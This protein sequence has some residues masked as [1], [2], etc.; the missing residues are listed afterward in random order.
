M[1]EV[2]TFRDLATWEGSGNPVR[3][4][5]FGDPVARSL[6]PPMQNAALAAAGETAQYARFEITAPELAPALRKLAALNF[7]GVNLTVPHKIAAFSL[8]DEC[9]AFA[10]QVGAINTIR[11]QSGR[12]LGANTDGAGFARGIRESFGMELQDLRGLVLGAAGGAGQA[13]VAQC[14][15][16]GAAKI[17]LVNRTADKAEALV[18]RY[19]RPG[20]FAVPWSEGSLGEVF[21]EIDLI[22]NATPL[23]LQ[24]T[25]PSPLP[26]SLLSTTH[27]V[28]DLNYQPTALLAAA[29]NAGARAASGLTM[30]LHQG[31]LAF[32]F[33]FERPAPLAAMRA[34]LG[35]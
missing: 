7:I 29:A 24:S 14:A 4:G 8:I 22:V 2:Y 5:V 21:P 13:V 15:L 28:Y 32:E 30:L 16:A 26:A 9:D 20:I 10:Q 6:S 18:Q 3:L 12:M 1:K 23:G 19:D 11:F 35:L 17:A 34:A 25:D 31:A 27:C 33:W